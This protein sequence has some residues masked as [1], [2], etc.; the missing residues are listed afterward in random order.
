MRRR[1]LVAGLALAATGGSPVWAQQPKVPTIGYFS[2]RSAAAE[3]PVRVPFLKGLDASGFTDGRNVVID[4]RFAEGQRDRLPML[5]AGLVRSQAAVLVAT[6]HGAALVAKAATATIPIVFTS[7]QDP[8]AVGLVASLSRPGGNATGVSLLTSELGPKRLA[9]LRE[10]LAKLGVIA[11]LFDPDS[12]SASLQIDEVK[13]GAQAIGQPVLVLPAGNDDQTE[14]A[15]AIIAEQRVGGILH[16]ASTFFQAIADKL[17][18]LAARHAIPAL[19]EWREFVTAGGL[20]SYSTSRTEVGLQLGNYVGRIL[21]GAAPADL[22]VV[23]SAKFELVIN[24][25]TAKALGLTLPQALLAS[26]DE[27]VE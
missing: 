5:A 22:P 23:R 10:L 17:V 19:Y 2:N 7:G 25:K 6:E 9:L 3:A 4:Y 8:V 12:P 21:K 16:G 13:A 27:V 26:A 18:A 1:D 11:F 15:F 14:K 20:M 24:L